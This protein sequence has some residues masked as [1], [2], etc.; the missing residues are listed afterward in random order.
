MSEHILPLGLA[1][2]LVGALSSG[3]KGAEADLFPLDA[4][5]GSSGG[6][7][8]PGSLTQGASSSGASNPLSTST[9]S[10]GG[11]DGAAAPDSGEDA[12]D[13]RPAQADA[14]AEGASPVDASPGDDASSAS[15]V[16][17]R[18]LRMTP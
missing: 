5:Q 17:K 9:G 8:T 14:P 1:F 18:R 6:S 10:D 3:C 16:A 11:Y 4:G 2:L 12:Q 15:V 13:D 7:G